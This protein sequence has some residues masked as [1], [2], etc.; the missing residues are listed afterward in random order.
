MDK[1]RFPKRR[2]SNH[3]TYCR[4]PVYERRCSKPCRRIAC[5]DIPCSCGHNKGRLYT[6][7]IKASIVVDMTLRYTL[8]HEVAATRAVLLLL[9]RTRA[10]GQRTQRRIEPSGNEANRDV[11]LVAHNTQSERIRAK[12]DRATCQVALPLSM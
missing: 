4:L 7:A 3:C 5:C 12:L 11:A 9:L 2:R 6:S 8:P 1:H 10:Q